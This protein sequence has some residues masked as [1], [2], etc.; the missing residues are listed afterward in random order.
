MATIGKWK[1]EAAREAYL[2]G[3]AA[4]AE[5]WPAG[6][7]SSTA[8]VVTSHG[9]TH[10]R[11]AGSGAGTP[12]V[13][14]HPLGGNGLCW[15]PIIEQL[16]RDR[17]VYALDTIGAPG[18][19]E[20]TAP[21]TSAADY[22]V[23]IEEVLAA[24]TIDRAHVFGYSDGAW[25]ASMAGVHGST[26]LAS[27]TLI[28]PGAGIIRPPW[29]LLLKM[30]RFGMNPSPEKL[31]RFSAY[32]TPGLE[33]SPEEIALS[34]AALDYKAP[35]LWP[36]PLKDAELRA[37]TT[38]TLVIYGAESVLLPD[39]GAAEKRILG[40]I[41]DVEFQ[42]VPSVGHGLLFQD[43]HREAVVRRVLDFLAR[44]DTAAVVRD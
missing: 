7:E 32:L 44:H 16:S 33:P 29:G 8:D 4:L 30:I 17:T 24:L 1:N 22:A 9:K 21:I 20:Q 31:R 41:P 28:E 42:L 35:A 6:V 39:P 23:W 18:L 40:N 26:R 37:I 12:L 11:Q 14:I 2:E 34:M 5:R 13:L 36:K 3:Y 25:R 43:S 27:L 10:V 15:Y 19:S 38:P